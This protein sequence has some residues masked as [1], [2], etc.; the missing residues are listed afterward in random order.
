MRRR[1][2]L[3]TYPAAVKWSARSPFGA[4]PYRRRNW[5]IFC[6]LASSDR[7][8]ITPALRA[9][10]LWTFNGGRSKARR[11]PLSRIACRHLFLRRCRNSSGSNW[12]RQRAR[13]ICLSSTT[14]SIQPRTEWFS[15]RAALEQQCSPHIPRGVW[16]S[17]TKTL[18]NRD[19]RAA[20]GS[21][22]RLLV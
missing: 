1:Q 5:R 7:C 13:P 2:C 21:P 16:G 18:R 14:L 4:P 20:L 8:K 6:L 11:T 22:S 19:R 3:A 15:V 9:R 12:N 17:S 10:L